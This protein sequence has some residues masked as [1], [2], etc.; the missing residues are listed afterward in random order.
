M[1]GPTTERSARSRAPGAGCVVGHRQAQPVGGCPVPRLC[2]SSPAPRPVPG[3]APPGLPPGTHPGAPDH[4]DGDGREG[5]PPKALCPWNHQHHGHTHR[6]GRELRLR[7]NCARCRS[8]RQHQSAISAQKPVPSSSGS[9]TIVRAWLR[10]LLVTH[11]RRV[12]RI[13]SRGG[14]D[15]GV[16]SLQLWAP[17]A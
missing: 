3:T 15:G 6:G 11:A 5:L 9:R 10:R 2:S 4:P 13:R 14:A 8:S 7:L 1:K 12:T 16:K 17:L